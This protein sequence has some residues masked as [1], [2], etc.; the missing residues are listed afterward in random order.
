[1]DIKILIV[2]DKYENRE[3]L[4]GVAN[5]FETE[6]F[7]AESG[8]EAVTLA[9]KVPFDIVLMDVMMPQMDGYEAAGAI[10]MIPHNANATVVFI[11][12]YDQEKKNIEKAYEIGGID[13]LFKPIDVYELKKLLSLY[14]RFINKEKKIIEKLSEKNERLKQA[15]TELYEEISK[16][17][18]IEAQLVESQESFRSIVD[19]SEAAILVVNKEGILKFANNASELIFR[20]PVDELVGNHIGYIAQ[21]DSK[22]EI[23]IF[24][25]DGTVGIGEITT[26]M[27]SWENKSAWLVLVN[28]ITEHKQL[29]EKLEKAK[30]KAQES[31]RL[32]SAFLSNMSH[33]IRTPMNGIVGFVELIEKEEDKEKRRYFSNI[34]KNCS[35]HLLNL[36]NDIIDISKI[37]AGQL[38]VRSG[39]C[40]V[41]ELM[42]N[43]HNFFVKN[44]DIQDK[45]LEFTLD[46]CVNNEETLVNTDKD[47][48]NQ[49]LI[50][51]IGN[52]IKF[53]NKGGISFGFRKKVR[54]LEFFVKDTGIGI[55]EDKLLSVF[56]RFMQVEDDNA[57]TLN[58]GTGLGL[59]ISKSLINLLGGS[60]WV[61]SKVGKGSEFKFTIPYKGINEI[62]P[63]VGRQEI[64]L[65]NLDSL[66]SKNV[67]IVDDN[68]VNYN[69]LNSILSEFKI[70]SKWAH[71]GLEAVNLTKSDHVD[72]ILMDIKMPLKNGLE[73][74]K[75]IRKFDPQVPIIAQT[76]YALSGEKEKCLKVGCNDYISKPIDKDE[77]VRLMLKHI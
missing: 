63:E 28:D 66:V 42:L 1:M 40:H 33:E 30:D 74:T 68:E 58:Q 48:L 69:L 22:A 26:T 15:N 37:E 70:N 51:L 27:T 55:P 6:I 72:L 61:D 73:A 49:V 52:A 34:V 16:R 75:D 13:F 46:C 4:L 3:L 21:F 45:G 53:T 32:K 9:K 62:K 36:I 2:D 67:L 12:A 11:T 71:N 20:R 65:E 56:D 7:E 64:K 59:A 24:R 29:H 17:K 76:A 47:R 35:A 25:K 44:K 19:K 38:A 31:D 23:N 57:S 50:N 41:E 5:Q 60:I 77:L 18:T 14:I 39:E 43:L 10:K 8:P 54:T